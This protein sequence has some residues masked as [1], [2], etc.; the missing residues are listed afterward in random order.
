MIYFIDI[1]NIDKI[2]DWVGQKLKTSVQ[3][4]WLWNKE[5]TSIKAYSGQ[6]ESP[7]T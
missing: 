3:T 5:Y 6:L 1:T 4:G 7:T 2:C